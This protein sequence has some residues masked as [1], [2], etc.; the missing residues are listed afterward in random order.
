VSG[1]VTEYVACFYQLRE[2]RIVRGTEYWITEGYQEAPQW[3]AHWTE[4]L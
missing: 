3:R 1:D 4:P 2:G